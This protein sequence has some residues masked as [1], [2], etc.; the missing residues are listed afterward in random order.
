[1]P[2]ITTAHAFGLIFLLTFWFV[3]AL[4]VAKLAERKGRS[5]AVYLVVSL[6]IGWVIPLVAAL[7]VRPHRV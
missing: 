4:F 5:F 6:I 7:V 3:P 1:M 2:A